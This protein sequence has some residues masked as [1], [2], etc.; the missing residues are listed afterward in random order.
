MS[1]RNRAAF[2]DRDGTIIEDI[3]YLGAPDDVRLLPNAVQGMIKLR[4]SGYLLVLVT[5]QS[6][7]ARGLFTPD[8][9]ER[10]QKRLMS[11]LKSG[12]ASLDAVYHCPHL[13]EGSV[14]PFNI[15]CD[16]R[17][18]KPGMLLRAAE[19]QDLDLESSVMIGA[20]ERDI[21]AGARV[22]CK[23]ILISES[24]GPGAMSADHTA[25]DLLGA[26]TI[27]EEHAEDGV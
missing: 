8:D 20:S 3:G 17:K 9:F 12:G 21:E 24:S 18:P 13:A 2:L 16:C 7:I 14:A 11:G 19:E 10:V 5:N 6:G 27:L 23:T 26:A 25:R 4:E 1:A 22:G 15:E